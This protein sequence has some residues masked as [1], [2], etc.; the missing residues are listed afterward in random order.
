MSELVQRQQY[1][2]LFPKDLPKADLDLVLEHSSSSC[3]SFSDEA[4]CNLSNDADV[5]PTIDDED[6]VESKMPAFKMTNTE[7]VR[8]VSSRKH[9]ISFF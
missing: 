6:E 7:I 1:T 8:G 2:S 3:S 4:S 9:W 5:V